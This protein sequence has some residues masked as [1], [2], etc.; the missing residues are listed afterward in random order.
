MEL[1]LLAYSVKVFSTLLTI[2]WNFSPSKVFCYIVS[3]KKKRN[4]GPPEIWSAIILYYS[5]YCSC[6]I[7]PLISPLSSLS[8]SLSHTH[9]RM[10]AHTH[11]HTRTHTH[12]CTH[13]QAHARK[14]MHACTHTHAHAYTHAHT[15]T[16]TCVHHAL[17][18][19]NN[20]L[21]HVF[22]I[23]TWGWPGMGYIYISL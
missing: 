19:S 4:Y 23:A 5:S 2:L 18:L 9:T 21:S 14:H 22:N 15:H 1:I 17:N 10:H 7:V 6:D 12:T 11:T 3:T 16:H 13:T 20:L 8:P